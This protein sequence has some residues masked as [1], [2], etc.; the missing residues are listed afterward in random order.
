ML[1]LIQLLLTLLSLLQL[2]LLLLLLDGLLLCCTEGRLLPQRLEL[3][4]RAARTHGLVLALIVG[5]RAVP[6]RAERLALDLALVHGFE[7]TGR[8]F[9]ATARARHTSAFVV[10]DGGV[11]EGVGREGA[12]VDM[13]VLVGLFIRV[14]VPGGIGCCDRLLV[15]WRWLCSLLA[16]LCRWLLLARQHWEV[17][18]EVVVVV[19]A[20][21]RQHLVARVEREA[22]VPHEVA[23]VLELHHGLFQRRH[24]VPEARS[25]EIPRAEHGR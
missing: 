18:E 12:T 19:A 24:G 9:V 23:H 17:P 21:C 20:G 3:V 22:R 10:H 1:S 13:I 11:A 25:D 8:V 6:R 16:L 2:L 14:I 5:A 15:H 7:A 4:G